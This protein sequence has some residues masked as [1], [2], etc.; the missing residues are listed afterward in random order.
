[1]A[2]GGEVFGAPVELEAA[3]PWHQDAAP[4]AVLHARDAYEEAGVAVAPGLHLGD[5]AGGVERGAGFRLLDPGEDRRGAAQGRRLCW[6][7]FP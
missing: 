2:D 3:A 6:C 5:V 7:Q 1:M 4:Y